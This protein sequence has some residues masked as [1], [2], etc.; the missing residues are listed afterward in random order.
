MV[1]E[2]SLQHSLLASILWRKPS[3]VSLLRSTN[4]VI[5]QQTSSNNNKHWHLSNNKHRHLW[6]QGHHRHLSQQMRRTFTDPPLAPS[7]TSLP[8]FYP[9]HQPHHISQRIFHPSLRS[10][11]TSQPISHL[12]LCPLAPSHTY[13]VFL[14]S[15]PLLQKDTTIIEWFNIHKVCR[16]VVGETQQINGVVSCY[17]QLWIRRV[18]QP[19]MCNSL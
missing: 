14:F 9:P 5:Q 17:Q 11:F 8:T 6:N 3:Y 2:V 16:Q 12:P 15:L 1:A 7:F 13:F 19:G 4:I 10:F 18:S